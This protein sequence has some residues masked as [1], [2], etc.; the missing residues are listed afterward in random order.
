MKT[1]KLIIFALLSLTI[2]GCAVF[3]G[4]S[5]ITEYDK[6]GNITK[7][8]VSNT[9]VLSN[10]VAGLKNKSWV[11]WEDSWAA[12]I[13]RDNSLVEDPTSFK[14]FVGK[15]NKGMLAVTKDQKGLGNIPAIISATG[16]SLEVTPKGVNN[17]SKNTVKEPNE[18]EKED[19]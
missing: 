9:P 3:V 13:G 17:T 15:S 18:S 8:T 2:S 19:K 4:E 5:T 11:A 1:I 14:L 12:F 16:S 10:A 7:I 6:D